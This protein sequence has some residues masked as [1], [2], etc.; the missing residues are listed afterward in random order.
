MTDSPSEDEIPQSEPNGLSQQ[1]RSTY[2]KRR[3]LVIVLGI[4]AVGLI[5]LGFFAYLL[6]RDDGSEETTP[7]PTTVA[8]SSV[9][10]DVVIIEA[11]GPTQSLTTTIASPIF[12][13]IGGVEFSVQAEIIPQEGPWDPQTPNDTI[14][15][16]A[17]GSVINYVFGLD[18]TNENRSLLERLQAG[19]EIA[20]TT[21]TDIK[22]RFVVTSR[23]MVSSSDRDIFAQRQ[24]QITLVLIEGDLEAERLVVQGTF[25]S[26]EAPDA[27][28]PGSVV[29]M[30][31]TAQIEGLQIT[32][33]GVRFQVDQA[34]IP[35]GFAYY[36]VD[37]QVQNVGT[38]PVNSDLLNLVL[39]DD[40]GNLYALN[41]TV[42][43]AGNN[44]MLSGQ[45]L[46]GQSVMVT[47]G[48]Q[49][50]AGIKTTT[51]RW[52]V[53]NVN[54][55]SQIQVNIPFEEGGG[56]EEQAVVQIQEVI[57][58]PEGSNIII[59][60]QITNLGQQPLVVE[61]GD[62]TLSSSGTVYLMLSTNP[63]F[64]WIIGPGQTLLYQ[65]TFQRP[66]TQSATFTIVNQSFDL[67]GF[68]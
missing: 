22:T 30:G 51:L 57:V 38:V 32:V 55:G 16:W 23:Q 35:S 8:E 33:T 27:L 14:A 42:S 11:V 13:N 15:L 3:P 49:I 41:P 47:A 68:R 9:D 43:Q 6:I 5:L 31:Q 63:A 1:I 52:Q 34:G 58:S 48:Y 67:T 39:V 20:I 29:E 45:V 36:T 19:D 60:G 18:D 44:P 24:P 2:N 54:T 25:T 65:V 59:T 26:S 37:Y 28:L 53:N 66:V 17:Y 40:L 56:T 21:R 12:L 46:P 62:V 4:A 64:P 7:K 61:V 50:P 10:T